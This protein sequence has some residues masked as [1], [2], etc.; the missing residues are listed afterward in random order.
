MNTRERQVLLAPTGHDVL[1]TH[2]VLWGAGV[3]AAAHGADVRLGWSGGLAPAPVVHGIGIEDL[4]GVVRQRARQALEPT[5]WVQAALPH[6]SGRALFSPRIK[7]LPDLAAWSAMSDVRAQHLDE[8]ISRRAAL[9]LRLL[10]ALGEPSSWHERNGKRRQDDAASRLE[11]QPR[12]QGSEFVGTLLRKLAES[13]ANRSLSEVAAGL[14]G[15]VRTDEAARDSP[16]SRSAANWRPP[17]ATDNALAWTAV[18]GLSCVPV[19]PLIRRQTRT[20][21]HVPWSRDQVGDRGAGHVAVPY[22]SGRWTVGRLRAVLASRALVNR[23]LAVLGGGGSRTDVR[24]DEQ[25]LRER[26]VAGLIL[27]PVGT[28]GST[29]SPERRVLSGRLVRFGSDDL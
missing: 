16:D 3:I 13:V 11:M 14:T 20:A 23:A 10:A 5:H 2:A 26:G 24:R 12:N 29:S 8:L 18:W 6:E 19:A 7:A 17:G 4:A 15:E 22:W 25:W 9:D 21:T 1:F 27:L 28:F